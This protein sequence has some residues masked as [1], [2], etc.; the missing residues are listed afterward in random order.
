MR[1]RDSQLSVITVC[2]R[3]SAK[4]KVIGCLV[5]FAEVRMIMEPTQ[6]VLRRLQLLSDLSMPG[7]RLQIRIWPHCHSPA[8]FTHHELGNCRGADLIRCRR[9]PVLPNMAPPI[10]IVQVTAVALKRFPLPLLS[11]KT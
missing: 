5:E 2:H 4:S 1:S 6:A 10:R 9:I 7:A 8:A 11:Y 3:R